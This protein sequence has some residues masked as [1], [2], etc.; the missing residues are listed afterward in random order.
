MS[1]LNLVLLTLLVALLCGLAG[2]SIGNHIAKKQKK[3]DEVM[4]NGS[5]HT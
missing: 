4:R 3:R 2:V 5:K 1:L